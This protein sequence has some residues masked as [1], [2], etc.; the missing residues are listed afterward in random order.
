VL[1]GQSATQ[2]AALPTDTAR[3]RRSTN[4]GHH[5]AGQPI[6]TLWIPHPS[7]EDLSPGTPDRRITALLKRAGWQVGKDRVERIS[8]P[9]SSERYCARSRYSPAILAG[10]SQPMFT[11][12]F[13]FEYCSSVRLRKTPPLPISIAWSSAC[14]LSRF[15]NP[16]PAQPTRRPCPVKRSTAS[17]ARG[18]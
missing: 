4:P 11:Q 12:R 2:H 1:T 6:W 7:D 14:R 18:S 17:W 13:S 16:R 9:G 15:D 10:V 8:S 5:F 3:R